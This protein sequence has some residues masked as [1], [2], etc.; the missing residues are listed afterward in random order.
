MPNPDVPIKQHDLTD[1]L[2]WRV[3]SAGDLLN[4]I[5]T[6]RTDDGAVE[7]DHD[8]GLLYYAKVLPS[9]VGVLE[10]ASSFPFP[11]EL[12]GWARILFV[13]KQNS[14][15]LLVRFAF[16][17][18]AK[19]FI[20]NCHIP[21]QLGLTP[22][23]IIELFHVF[24]EILWEAISELKVLPELLEDLF[25]DPDGGLPRYS[26]HQKVFEDEV[27]FWWNAVARAVEAEED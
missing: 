11:A 21:T 7:L 26:K 8:G 18:D 13:N 25:D 19:R 3:F 10:F 9:D 1:D 22:E 17:D 4:S 6:G 16:S 27:K 23:N 5:V 15:Q 24:E 2:L 14:E 20:A 12:D